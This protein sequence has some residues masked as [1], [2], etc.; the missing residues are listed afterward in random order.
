MSTETD[1]ITQDQLDL[2]DRVV[3]DEWFDLPVLLEEKGV[4]EA[5][6]D[7]ALGPIK[8]VGGKNGVCVIVLMSELEPEASN[9]TAARWGD[10]ITFQVVE[11]PL[12]NRGATGNGKSAALVATRIRQLVHLFANGYGG[13]WSFAGQAPLPAA[14]GKISYGVRFTRSGGDAA[15][16]LVAT[17]R[18]EATAATAPATVT[19]TCSTADAAIRYTLDGSYPR[20]TN[21]ATVIYTAP[22]AVATSAN[23]RAVAVKAGHR[24]SNVRHLYLS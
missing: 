15:L 21:P 23:I 22:F 4:T 8:A 12:A 11:W 2:H 9:A 10:S 7:K 17:P 6:V 3:D 16:P 20:A 19:L 5:D 18:I 14:A 13:T 1:I 24:A